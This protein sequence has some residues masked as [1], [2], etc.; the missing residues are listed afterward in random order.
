MTSSTY[1]N[2]SCAQAKDQNA[3]QFIAKREK[4]PRLRQI[5]TD[6]DMVKENIQRK[7]EETNF[8]PRMRESISSVLAKRWRASNWIRPHLVKVAYE[9]VGGNQLNL[10][11]P[12]MTASELFNISTY[13]ANDVFDNK[14]GLGGTFDLDF[15]IASHRVF[16]LAVESI[17]DL[18][19][20]V[21]AIKLNNLVASLSR[22]NNEVYRGQLIDLNDLTF[23]TIDDV[24][25]LPYED[26]LA[27]YLQ[28]CASLGGS[29]VKFCVSSGCELGDC[30]MQLQNNISNLGYIYGMLMQI[31][32]DLS[33]FTTDQHLANYSDLKNKK[34]TLPIYLVLKKYSVQARRISA[35]SGELGNFISKKIFDDEI[36]RE[37]SSV[38][39]DNWRNAL[40]IM[41]KYPEMN[42]RN[43]FSL[44]YETVFRSKFTKH[45]L[46]T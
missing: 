12:L 34:I 36:K 10:T 8:E 44:M 43:S 4:N 23:V 29:T 46:N 20:Q 24:L 38:I 17:L 22:A 42:L 25:N 5:R 18:R 41:D 2:T 26:Y 28:R 32:N 31:V 6:T 11:L 30:A 45:L 1:Y 13:L 21:S 3:R 9:V 37:I 39:R 15:F 40:D 33:E 16:H 35:N 19:G 27:M 14:H 7:F